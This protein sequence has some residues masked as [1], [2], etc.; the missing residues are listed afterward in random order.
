MKKLQQAWD[1]NFTRTYYY[2]VIVGPVL[3]KPI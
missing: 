1:N 3:H 2:S